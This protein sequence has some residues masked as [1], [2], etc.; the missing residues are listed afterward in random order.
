MHLFRI[1]LHN[2]IESILCSSAR[3]GRSVPNNLICLK[4]EEDLLLEGI[5]Q[6]RLKRA[7]ILV[8]GATGAI[9]L[10]R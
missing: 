8:V 4:V 5:I 7:R 6:G 3:R 1:I 2:S 9:T 10:C